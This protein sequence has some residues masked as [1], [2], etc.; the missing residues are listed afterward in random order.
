MRVTSISCA[1]GNIIYQIEPGDGFKN[2]TDGNAICQEALVGQDS[3]LSVWHD[4]NDDPPV[5]DEEVTV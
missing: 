3:D 4:T 2:V 5:E 1:S